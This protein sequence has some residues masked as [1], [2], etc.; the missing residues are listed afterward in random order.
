MN[1]AVLVFS[2]SITTRLHYIID[3]MEQ[4]F[5]HGF[6][7]TCDEDTFKDAVG[8]CR[9][10]YGYKRLC[11]DEIFIPAHVLLFESSIR[12]VRTECFERNGIKYFFRN[13]GDIHFDIFAAIFFLITRYEEYL[14]H[15]KDNYGRFS[16]ES[17]L[18]FKEKFLYI[19]L[20]N[21]WLEELRKLLSE[22]MERFRDPIQPFR[23]IATYDIDMAWSYRNKGLVRNAG[24][25][26]KLLL[27]ARFGLVDERLKVLK[28]KL[29]DPFDAYEWLDEIHLQNALEPVYFFLVSRRNSGVD[30]NIDPENK[31]FQEL[32]RD[33]SSKYE[34]G[35]HPSWASGDHHALLSEEKKYLENITQ[36]KITRSRQHFLRFN[37]PDT[38]RR[39]IECGISDEYSMGYGTI[40]GFRASIASPFWWYDLSRE[41]TT[42]LRVHPFCFMDANAY[43]EEGLKAQAALEELEMYYK[44]IKSVNGTMITIWHNSFLGNGNEFSEWKRIYEEFLQGIEG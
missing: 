11:D 5:G 41:I 27:K 16:H 33:I 42:N 9:I 35:L 44:V 13:E 3:F 20:V 43:F 40:N 17:S 10:N 21:I 37:L 24:S 7:I 36:K 18:A 19:P 26:F 1:N 2:H 22:K 28:G 30:K 31:E 38:Y 23:F 29:P 14:P 34:T 25:I 6:K 8:T 4:Y 32:I 15:K 12:P 39:L